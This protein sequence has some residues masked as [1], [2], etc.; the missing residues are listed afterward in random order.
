M[1]LSLSGHEVQTAH[2]GQQAS[3]KAETFKPQLI[4]LDIGLPKMNGYEVCRA[5]RAK[6]AGSDIVL[7][8]LTGWG[9]A[10]DLR[11]SKEAGFNAHM[12]KPVDPGALMDLLASLPA[13]VG[14][15]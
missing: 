5:I 2:D 12:V 4:L 13:S 6:P 15:F 10:E 11:R 1:L 9:Q 8:A 3:D 14:N 7:V